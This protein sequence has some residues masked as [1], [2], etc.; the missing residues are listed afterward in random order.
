LTLTKNQ[1]IALYLF[2]CC[3]FNGVVWQNL[4]RQILGWLVND[5]LDKNGLGLFLYN[6]PELCFMDLRIP[7]TLHANQWNYFRS[8][9]KQKFEK[10]HILLPHPVK[11]R[12]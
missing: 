10:H 11:R 6:I 8:S 2:I 12:Q 3:L 7:I 4:D 1:L 5:E 9:S